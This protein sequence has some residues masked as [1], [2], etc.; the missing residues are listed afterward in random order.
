MPASLLLSSFPFS[1]SS[2]FPPSSR[3]R[4]SSSCRRH[5]VAAA[6]AIVVIVFVAAAAAAAAAGIV[7]IVNAAAA[8]ATAVVVFVAGAAGVVVVAAVATVVIVVAAAAGVGVKGDQW[9]EM[10]GR[11]GETHWMG[12]PIPGSPLVF[13]SPIPSPI[14]PIPPV[15][16]KPT[17]IRLERG[18]AGQVW[19]PSAQP[20]CW[21]LSPHPL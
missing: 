20:G 9:G 12:L 15:E 1:W 7:V 3:C 8:V 6:A 13:P 19:L 17:H 21:W 2:S 4:R 16:Y 14:S 5:P 10:G 11:M 18:G